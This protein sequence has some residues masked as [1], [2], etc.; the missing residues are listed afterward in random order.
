MNNIYIINDEY[1]TEIKLIFNNNT[2]LLNNNFYKFEFISKDSIKIFWTIDT[3]EIFITN[4]SY[5]YFVNINLRNNIKK[6]FLIN[7]QW[8]DQAIINLEKNTLFRIISKT[9]CGNFELNNK[10]LIIIW[11]NFEKENYIK[12]D[13][14]TYVEENK[15]NKYNTIKHNKQYIPIHIF[16]HICCIGDN[17][18]DIFIEQINLIK[19]SGLYNII[20]K[21]HLGI[22]GHINN[23]NNEIFN[24]EKF[25][26]EYIDKK[27]IMY[28][29][30][31]INSIKNFCDNNKEEE[32]YIL[33]IHTKGVRK[34]GNEEVTKSWR[35]MMQYFLIEKYID[36]IKNLNK[37]DTLGCNIVNQH[38]V[39]DD[40]SSINKN[41]NYHYSGNFWWSKKTYINKLCYLQT[42]LTKNSINT[43][44][45]AENWI[46][47]NIPETKVGIL[48]Q[49]DTN[50]HP[51]HRY[52]FNYY[53]E[54]KFL[55]KDLLD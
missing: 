50:T 40:E 34:A 52:V 51:Y 14:Y 17:W 38:C 9:Q 6:I 20:T 21:I 53:R 49:D 15:Y 2:F 25:E 41:H 54:M 32:I 5:L 36:C 13:D 37:Y 7:E 19:K 31:T 45:R 47:S 26:I 48:F 42:D 11:N 27:I 12:Y 30:N 33:Y 55:I 46:L 10:K 35:N 44:Y 8:N 18:K 16:I 39:K 28:E 24:D 23:I 29:I 4:D 22:L 3:F 43:R 1:N